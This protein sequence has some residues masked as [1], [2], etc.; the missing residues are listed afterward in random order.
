MKR[1]SAIFCGEQIAFLD[2]RIFVHDFYVAGSN[3]STP[4][5]TYPL[6]QICITDPLRLKSFTIWF[7][8]YLCT[9]DIW[10]D[11]QHARASEKSSLSLL[12]VEDQSQGCKAQN[13]QYCLWSTPITTNTFLAPWVLYISFAQH[14]KTT[15]FRTNRFYQNSPPRTFAGPIRQ[16][17]S[18]PLPLILTHC[19]PYSPPCE[20]CLEALATCRL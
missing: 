18:L 4:F 14:L 7:L 17:V 12:V 19:C 5:R 13:L 2:L 3:H 6:Y 9:N 11:E 8:P 10:M 16:R 1:L 20:L 15:N